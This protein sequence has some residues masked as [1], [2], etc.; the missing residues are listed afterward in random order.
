LD[1]RV[2]FAVCR[3]LLDDVILLTE[4]EIAVGMRHAYACER[5]IVE[6]AGAVGIAA[7][8]AGKIVGNGPIVAILS[9]ANV[10]MEQ[11]RRVINGKAALCGE[12]RP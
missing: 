7:L 6:G 9:G 5:Q 8:L 2:T 3:E 10:D 1:N 11:H 4:A 12:E